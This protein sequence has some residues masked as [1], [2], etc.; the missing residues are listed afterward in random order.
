MHGRFRPALSEVAR[1]RAMTA[2]AL[3]RWQMEADIPSV[4]LVVSE[5]LAQAVRRGA[6]EIELRVEARGDRM[7][8]GVYEPAF[9]PSEGGPLWFVG[10]V[11]ADWGRRRH[12]G[13]T[14]TW[15]DCPRGVGIDVA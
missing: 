13:R 15:A 3:R 12:Q 14:V 2:G 9:P 5:M 1:A 4:E 11:A 8:V 7:R 6:G 10:D